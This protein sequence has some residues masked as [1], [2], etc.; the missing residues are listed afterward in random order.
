ML[1]VRGGGGRVVPKNPL[2]QTKV[3]SFS[4]IVLGFHIYACDSL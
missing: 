2:S 3:I 1:C 4:P